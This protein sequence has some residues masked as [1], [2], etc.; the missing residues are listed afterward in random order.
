MSAALTHV[1][2]H[3]PVLQ[4]IQ[5]V[6]AR[7]GP[8]CDTERAHPPFEIQLRQISRKEEMT[9]LEPAI[10]YIRNTIPL[11]SKSQ[12]GLEFRNTHHKLELWLCPW[13]LLGSQE[14]DERSCPVVTKFGKTEFPLLNFCK[15][16]D[17]NGSSDISN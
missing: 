5:K 10:Y 7:R 16:D 6:I 3:Y 11:A 8:M 1:A 15:Q 17:H 12:D 14:E 13:N 9:E 2:C 4:A